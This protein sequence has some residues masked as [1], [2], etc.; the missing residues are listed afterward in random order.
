[1]QKT[2]L[3]FLFLVV[4]FATGFSQQVGVYHCLTRSTEK[5]FDRGHGVGID[6]EMNVLRRG[7]VAV[8]SSYS[9]FRYDYEDFYTN[10]ADGSKIGETVNPN[11]SWFS[12]YLRYGYDLIKR[13]HS[14]VSLGP[15][16]GINYFSINEVAWIYRGDFSTVD[17][18]R[19]NRKK[20]YS[21][22]PK[23]GVYMEFEAK[24]LADSPFS[25]FLSVYKSLDILDGLWVEGSHMPGALG[26]T[27]TQLGIRYSFLK[28]ED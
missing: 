18:Y 12:V 14:S 15:V 21:N 4:L 10:S 11:N 9:V 13:E 8:A 7:S 2:C 27:T 19:D 17:A 28:D 3:I 1:M 6:A 26:T 20:S 22:K 5:M 23:C 24:E 16:L 25:V